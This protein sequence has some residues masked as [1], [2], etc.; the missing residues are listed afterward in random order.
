[1]VSRR[2]VSGL[3]AWKDR[4]K[5]LALSA[6]AI[7]I[8]SVPA[9]AQWVTAYYINTSIPVSQVPWSKATHVVDMGMVPDGSGNI[10]GIAGSDADAFVSAAHAAGV[11][12]L[13]NIFD[14][15]SNLSAFGSSIT[16]NLSGFVGNISSFV[17]A[18]NYDGVD[19][20][21]EGGNFSGGDV[22][23]Y[24]NFLNALRSALGPNKTI[25]M[26]V[27]ISG[28]LGTVV[29]TANSAINQVNTMC[30][31]MDQ[32]NSDIY[33]NMSL[34]LA[35]GD[36]THNSCASIAGFFANYISKAKIGLGVPFYGRVWNGCANSSC[37]DGLHSLGQTW[38]SE[39]NNYITYASLVGSSYWSYPH[40][41]DSA[42]AASY[43]SID[44]SGASSDRFISFT[45]S[46]QINATAQYMRAQG[47]GGIM[48]YEVEYDLIP[49]Q[50]G[51]AMH[52]LAT[53]VWSAVFG[54]STPT[55]T[56]TPS[57][58]AP[59]VSSGSPTGTLAASTTQATMS[60]ATNQAATCK[61]ATP[62]ARRI[63]R[64]RIPSPLPA[65]RRTPLP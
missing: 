4:L 63:P 34:Y 19:V 40:V 14:N 26:S 38:A 35:A 7:G 13:M 31:D 15:G 29:Q 11:K 3:R 33:Y 51:D 9:R 28:G 59:V 42:H 5:F 55:P 23:N 6:I 22:Q 49:G 43:I 47:Y 21:W 2:S 32:F 65:E 60:V 36:N 45:D 12:A 56:P 54:T 61:Y 17:N 64:C 16:N 20:D 30:Y 48:E 58:S 62:R 52:P 10:S 1:M 8:L 46:N 25:S 37:S 44:L 24:I 39:S 50:S 53:A 57:P 18:H 41:Y 27:Y